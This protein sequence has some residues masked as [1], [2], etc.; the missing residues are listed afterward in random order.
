MASAVAEMQKQSECAQNLPCM[1]PPG[2]ENPSCIDFKSVALEHQLAALGAEK[3]MWEHAHEVVRLQIE[4]LRSSARAEVDRSGPHQVDHTHPS[5]LNEDVLPQDRSTVTQK[6]ANDAP[7]CGRTA[8]AT[9]SFKSKDYVNI[10]TN[11]H[12]I[13]RENEAARIAH[14]EAKSKLDSTSQCSTKK[15]PFRLGNARL[16]R[17]V[18]T[19]EI[20]VGKVSESSSVCSDST[21]DALSTASCTV[22][23]GA[24]SDS[25]TQEDCS[26]DALVTLRV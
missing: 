10:Q 25:E 5:T 9:A 13:I 11:L 15:S 8:K 12:K 21:A 14:I 26:N 23:E 1:A 19:E 20:G 16:R 24:S 7:S 3:A 4:C 17:K 6:M 22:S 2:L 18:E